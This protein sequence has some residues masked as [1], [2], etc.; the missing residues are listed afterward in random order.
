MDTT[1]INLVSF[2]SDLKYGQMRHIIMAL[3]FCVRDLRAENWLNGDYVNTVGV[4]VVFMEDGDIPYKRISLMLAKQPSPC[5]VLAC[6]LFN[7]KNSMVFSKCSEFTR[8]PCDKLE[9]K[10]R[11]QRLHESPEAHASTE[12]RTLKKNCTRLNMLG[13]SAIF[14]RAVE[15]I[16][17]IS[18]CNT[19]VLIEGETGTGKELAARAIHYNSIRQAYPFVPVNCGALPDNLIENELFGHERGAFTGAQCAYTGLIGQANGGTLFLDE[20]ETLPSKGQVAL[21]RFLEDQEYRPLGSMR[22]IITDVRVIAA[23]NKNIIE[24]C[25]EGSFRQDLY[26]RLNVM[27]I[28]L[29]PLRDRNEDIE[30]LAQHFLHECSAQYNQPPKVLHH[31][32]VHWIKTYDWPGNVRELKNL[33]EREFLLTDDRLVHISDASAQSIQRKTKA[34]VGKNVKTFHEAKIQVVGEFEREYLCELLAKTAGNVTMAAK[35]A[36]KERRA[37]GKLLKKHDID[38]RQFMIS[39]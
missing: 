33:I 4:Y 26:F 28:V 17:K 27:S 12:G 7:N 3:G 31:N 39:E 13:C 5:F 37:L 18:N 34:F 20:I 14:L 21:L 8:W 2:G 15:R 10:I 1:P 30:L 6:H 23:S 32:S 19:P 24:L 11:L 22:P 36:G 29:P 16:K 35:L 9:L 38:R 25:E